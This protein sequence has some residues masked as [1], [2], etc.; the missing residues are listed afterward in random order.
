MCD[1][2]RRVG[3]DDQAA[4]LLEPASGG[5]S[6]LRQSPEARGGPAFRAYRRTLVVGGEMLV[7]E[8]KQSSGAL[9]QGLVLAL[10]S[11]VLRA[12]QSVR[13]T[14]KGG[15]QRTAGAPGRTAPRVPNQ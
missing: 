8:R 2:G 3:A 13:P 6:L 14:P 1:A 5:G 15:A 12:P 4:R 7:A 9:D 11:G 10:R